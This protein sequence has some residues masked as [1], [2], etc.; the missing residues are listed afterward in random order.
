MLVLTYLRYKLLILIATDNMAYYEFMQSEKY[1]LINNFIYVTEFSMK[2]DWNCTFINAYLK[3]KILSWE[4]M[5]LPTH[6][7]L[8]DILYIGLLDELPAIL[9]S[10]ST[11]PQVLNHIGMVGGGKP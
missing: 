3:H 8:M 11:M 7:S 2:T 4:R 6:N 1:L 9:N 10:F 5:K